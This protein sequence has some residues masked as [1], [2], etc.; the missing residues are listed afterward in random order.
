MIESVYISQ[1]EK[2]WPNVMKDMVAGNEY[3]PIVLRGGKDWPEDTKELFD[4]VELFKKHEKGPNPL[5]WRIEWKTRK[6]RRFGV[7]TWPEVI[8]VET[9]EDYLYL[10]GKEDI[11]SRFKAQISMLLAWRPQMQDFLFQKPELVLSLGEAWT[12]IRA[13]VDYLLAYDVRNCYLRSLPVP[14]HTKFI[15]QYRNTILALLQ[16]IDQDRFPPQERELEAALGLRRKPFLFPMRWLDSTRAAACSADMDIF[17]APVKYL[18]GVSWEVRKVILVENETNL[19]TLPPI[20]D[21]FALFSC[22]KALSLLEDISLF[23]RVQIYYWGDLDEEGYVMLNT[24]RGLYGHAISLFMDIE[25]VTFH[26]NQLLSQPNPYKSR[27]LPLLTPAES[28]AFRLLTA[29]NGRI[30]QEQLDQ[31]FVARGLNTLTELAD[32]WRK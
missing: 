14:V 10:T 17:A 20:L 18:A 12:G 31:K 4:R 29:V 11:A 13:V 21:S 3:S 2:R 30:E 1:L 16:Y 23:R 8:T 27:D 9:E 19:L 28:L 7:Q 32:S 6:S 15:H 26:K 5:G 24:I 25:T 22:G